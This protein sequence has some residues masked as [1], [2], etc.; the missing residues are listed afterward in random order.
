M[1]KIIVV[2]REGK[3]VNEDAE[4]L[5]IDDVVGI[6]SEMVKYGKS[7]VIFK[8]MDSEY[9]GAHGIEMT[10][11]LFEDLKEYNF[12][13]ADRGVMVNLNKIE[14]IDEKNKLLF[15]NNKKDSFTVSKTRWNEVKDRFIK[16]NCIAD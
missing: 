16:I 6:H 11:K 14:S 4:W 13:R 2:G 5:D 15:Y 1:Y 9:I 12:I 10:M 8:T 7:I 3:K